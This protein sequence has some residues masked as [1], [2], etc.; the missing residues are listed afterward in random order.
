MLEDKLYAISLQWGNVWW[1]GIVLH[2]SIFH[3]QCQ[4]ARH[5]VEIGHVCL[6]HQSVAA[7]VTAGHN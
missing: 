4:E 5:L 7:E 2:R 1:V 6:F 3:S